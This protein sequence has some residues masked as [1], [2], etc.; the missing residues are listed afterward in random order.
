[1]S[2]ELKELAEA[3]VSLKYNVIMVNIVALCIAIVGVYFITRIKKSAEL[4]EINNNFETVKKQQTELAKETGEIKQSID[5]QNIFYQI[6]LSAYH[7]KSI[8]AINDIYVS[9][10]NLR[11]STKILG[12]NLDA[13]EWKKFHTQIHK[14]RNTFDTNKIWIPSDLSKHIE[15]VALEIEKRSTRFF[16]ASKKEEQ[17]PRLPPGKIEKISDELEKFYDYIHKEIDLIFE[18]LVERITKKISI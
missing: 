13:E 7:E 12:I 6:K 1:M 9:L 4:R 5:Q 15:N 2:S 8:E 11:D 10:I 14:F 18:D 17:I 3:L 16:I